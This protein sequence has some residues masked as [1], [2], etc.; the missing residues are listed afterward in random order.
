MTVARLALVLLLTAS[1]SP[2][3]RGDDAERAER[4]KLVGAWT[5]VSVEVNGHKVPAEAIRNFQFVFTDAKMTRKRGDKVESEAGYRVDPSRSPKW[6]DALG[7]KGEKGPVVPGLYELAGDTL[8]VC[9]R[10]DYK[11]KDGTL[12]DKPQRPA[13]MEAGEGSGQVL[14]VLKREKP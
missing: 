6:L 4:A 2:G 11:K 3:L 14:M 13:K 5:V 1:L 10:N 9:F 7:P 8:T 12:V